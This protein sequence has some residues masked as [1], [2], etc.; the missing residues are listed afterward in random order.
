MCK[1]AATPPQTITAQPAASSSAH[2][3]NLEETQDSFGF[4]HLRQSQEPVFEDVVNNETR[5]SLL[6]SPLKALH[7]AKSLSN[8]MYRY[9]ESMA[10]QSSNDVCANFKS[11]VESMGNES[12]QS[13]LE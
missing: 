11:L 13:A 9:F 3:S 12:S 4:T 2:D 1:N 6:P 10:S 7:D 5:S 8:D